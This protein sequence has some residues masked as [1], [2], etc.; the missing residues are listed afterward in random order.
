MTTIQGNSKY[1]VSQIIGE[2]YFIPEFEQAL[3]ARMMTVDGIQNGKYND[4]ALVTLWN[5]FWLLL[6]DDP[7]CQRHPFLELCDLCEEIFNEQM[8]DL[9]DPFAE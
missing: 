9:E 8:D 3:K 4:Q 2:K 1:L 5:D 6:P 7:S